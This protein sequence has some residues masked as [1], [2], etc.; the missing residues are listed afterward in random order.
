MPSGWTGGRDRYVGLDDD[1]R[2]ASGRLHTLGLR[3]IG[4]AAALC[5]T[6]SDCVHGVRWSTA[7]EAGPR[8]R[9]QRGL[10]SL[11]QLQSLQ[12]DGDAKLDGDSD[13]GSRCAVRWR[14]SMASVPEWTRWDAVGRGGSGR[15]KG[16]PA[17]RGAAERPRARLGQAP[18]LVQ[19]WRLS[20]Y[21]FPSTP[22]PAGATLPLRLPWPAWASPLPVATTQSRSVGRT[23]AYPLQWGWVRL[24]RHVAVSS[25]PRTLPG[26]AGIPRARQRQRVPLRRHATPPTRRPALP[27]LGHPASP[28]PSDPSLTPRCLAALGTL[29]APKAPNKTARAWHARGRRGEGGG[30]SR[31]GGMTDRGRRGRGLHHLR[32][33]RR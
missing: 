6:A 16:I 7:C 24:Q 5:R 19:S 3:G 17:A 27:H 30:A 13:G 31:G 12:S 8:G 20:R 11:Q 15:G 22:L 28:A 33:R 32:Q 9:G 14:A 26:L 2:E 10:Q 29:C 1:P 4:P 18:V 25:R 21:L 23:L